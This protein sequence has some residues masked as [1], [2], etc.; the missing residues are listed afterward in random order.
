[1][2]DKIMSFHKDIV[3]YVTKN[4]ISES[5]LCFSTLNI[6]PF[7]LLSAPFIQV[8]STIPVYKIWEFLCP[9]Q[10]VD[11]FCLL[12]PIYLY[13]RKLLCFKSAL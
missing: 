2:L 6:F 9:L 7:H 3:F 12:K 10:Q 4:H 8:S 11:V 5:K 13:P 1:M